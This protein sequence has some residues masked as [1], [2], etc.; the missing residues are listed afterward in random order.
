MRRTVDEVGIE[1]QR[2]AERGQLIDFIGAVVLAAVI[3][4]IIAVKI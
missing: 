2:R 3:A 4:F 1:A